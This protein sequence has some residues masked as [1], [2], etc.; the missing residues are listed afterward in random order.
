[1]DELDAMSYEQLVEALD[2]LV[3]RMA[4]GDIGI[5]E[6][7]DLYEQA[8]RLHAAAARRLERVRQRIE[9]L[10][11]NVTDARPQSAAPPAEP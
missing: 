1:M 10:E 4:T 2:A 8:G 9:G 6:V 5:E 7:A 3:A 11:G